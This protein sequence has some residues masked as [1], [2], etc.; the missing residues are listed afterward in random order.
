MQT[1]IRIRI[2]AIVVLLAVVV[3]SALR[4]Y[5]AQPDSLRIYGNVDIR[6]VNLAFRVAGRVQRLLVDEGDAVQPGQLLAQLDPAPGER[7]VAEGEANVAALGARLALLRA[8]YRKEDIA[9]AAAQVD[10]RRAALGNAEQ[11][12]ARE[13]RLAGSGASTPERLEQAQAARDE[14]VARL[15]AGEQALAES[16]NGFRREEVAEAAANLQRAKAALAQARLRLDDTRLRAPSAGVVLTRAVEPG[17]MAG[18]STTVL[19][20]SLVQPVWVRAYVKETDLAAARP[21]TPV[22]IHVDSLPGRTFDGTV[23]F[24][25]PTA[26]FTP[27]NVETP[28]LRTDL[29]YRLRIIAQDPRSE[30]RQGMPVTVDLGRPAA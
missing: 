14:A 3:V 11:A 10:E 4:L 1:H 15:A 6:E 22:R 8:G 27:K 26:E 20:L 18:T 28:D 17:A 30:L 29:V 16:R 21:G 2:A 19:T 7:E 23:G 5:S 12:L 25:S 9:Q 13:T 24:V